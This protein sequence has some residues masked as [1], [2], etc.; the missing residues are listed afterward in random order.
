MIA[1]VIA[2]V[3]FYGVLT[4][5]AWVYG[6]TTLEANQRAMEWQTSVT[7]KCG[8]VVKGIR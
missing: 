1:G 6:I 3:F 7:A 5:A 4:W 8:P 2:R